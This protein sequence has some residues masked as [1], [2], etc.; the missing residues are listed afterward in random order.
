MEA[1]AQ[2]GLLLLRLGVAMGLVELVLGLL[3]Q[4]VVVVVQAQ[5]LHL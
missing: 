4:V 1:L 3:S 2:L 5:I